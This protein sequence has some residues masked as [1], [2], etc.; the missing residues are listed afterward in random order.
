MNFNKLRSICDDVKEVAKA[1]KYSTILKLSNDET[2][3]SRLTPFCQKSQEETD[4]CTIYIV[5]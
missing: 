5:S 2:K 3:V 1:L 4:Q